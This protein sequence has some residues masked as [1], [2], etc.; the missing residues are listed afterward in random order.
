MYGYCAATSPFTSLCLFPTQYVFY[1][2]AAHSRRP[3]EC[4]L[5]EA[6]LSQGQ[7]LPLGRTL[8]DSSKTN[9]PA[10]FFRLSDSQAAT[11][12]CDDTGRQ[13]AR[14]SLTEQQ[15]SSMSQPN[16]SRRR[17]ILPA[18][19]SRKLPQHTFPHHFA[20]TCSSIAEK[21]S[22]TGRSESPVGPCQ[23]PRDCCMQSGTIKSLPQHA[24]RAASM[25]ALM[26]VAQP[27]SSAEELL[28][29]LQSESIAATANISN[30]HEQHSGSHDISAL[31]SFKAN[32]AGGSL[33]STWFLLPIC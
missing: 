17:P 2:L 23:K 11:L 16:H 26:A 27:V 8:S 18:A 24:V 5:H 3:E 4:T 28:K 7:T 20:A 22:L 15:L 12:D 30:G 31:I 14:P 9:F 21:P 6:E 29:R 25:S 10:S 19:P 13:T 1:L 33:T 32:H